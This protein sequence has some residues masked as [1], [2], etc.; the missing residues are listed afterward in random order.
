MRAIWLSITVAGWGARQG[1][2][3]VNGSLSP[4]WWRENRGSP[5]EFEIPFEVRKIVQQRPLPTWGLI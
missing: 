3:Q 1:I 5:A 4:S 2:K